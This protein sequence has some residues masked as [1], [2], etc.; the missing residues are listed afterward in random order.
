MLTG[1]PGNAAM[2]IW[3][4]IRKVNEM[5]KQTRQVFGRKVFWIQGRAK[6][7]G[8]MTRIVLIVSKW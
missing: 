7:K 2:Q 6:L 5:T 3:H 8:T 1:G 4:L